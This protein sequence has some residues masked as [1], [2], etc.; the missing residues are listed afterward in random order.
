M[1]FLK[2]GSYRVLETGFQE[3]LGGYF[4]IYSCTDYVANGIKIYVTVVAF[5]GQ[6]GWDL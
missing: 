5:F 1:E 2:L 6:V 4:I 3:Q